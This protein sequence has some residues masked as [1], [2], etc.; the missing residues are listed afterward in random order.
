MMAISMQNVC[1]ILQFITIL[2]SLF[3]Y[4]TNKSHRTE[5]CTYYNSNDA[6]IYPSHMITNSM[7]LDVSSID[8][9]FDIKL[10]DNCSLLCNIFYF[11]DE[12]FNESISLS[13][14]SNDLQISFD[15][16]TEQKVDNNY[17]SLSVDNNYHHIRFS[18]TN[19][20]NSTNVIIVD[21]IYWYYEPSQYQLTTNKRYALYMCSPFDACVNAS[22]KN[23][24][25]KSSPTQTNIYDVSCGDTISNVLHYDHIH[26][27][28]FTIN[29]SLLVN[30][31]SCTSPS[32]IK[33]TIQD[34]NGSD[35]SSQYCPHGDFCGRCNNNWNFLQNFTMEMNK[36]RY[37]LRIADAWFAHRY[38][39]AVICK[40]SLQTKLIANTVSNSY[41]YVLPVESISNVNDWF[42]AQL[43]C[44]ET[45]GTSLATVVTEQDILW[46]IDMVKNNKMNGVWIGLYRDPFVDLNW[47]WVEGTPYNSN[48]SNLIWNNTDYVYLM[49]E[50]IGSYLYYWNYTEP[51]QNIIWPL[52]NAPH[53]NRSWNPAT[54]D[55]EIYRSVDLWHNIQIMEDF[56]CPKNAFITYWDSQLFVIELNQIHYTN[57]T[58]STTSYN[59]EHVFYDNNTKSKNNS[60]QQY[61]QYQSSLYLYVSNIHS[62]E[63]SDILFDINLNSLEVQ[64][65]DVPSPYH[66]PHYHHLISC[67]VATESEVFIIGHSSTLNYN[68]SSTAWKYS[69]WS[70]QNGFKF[71][72]PR[73]CAMT[74]DHMYIY[75]FGQQQSVIKYYT[76]LGTFEY[77]DTISF[78]R[79]SISTAITAPNGKI[80]IHGCHVSAWETLVFDPNEEEFEQQRISMG[81]ITWNG[82]GQ[83]HLAIF[84]DNILLLLQNSQVHHSL[85]MYFSVTEIFAVHF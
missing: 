29:S 26:Y 32:D 21:Q 74:E 39:F 27:Y 10:N 81:N 59:W 18:H 34:S 17:F 42:T 82:Y 23:I 7:V 56:Y 60:V 15:G 64:H 48:Y 67:M 9:E 57:I 28:Y 46:I 68:V 40:L 78:C 43:I 58:L 55:E 6:A 54:Y 83:V 22:V 33:I 16:L 63:S 85:S 24:C 12:N 50:E 2:I 77:L 11:T 13:L 45:F 5:D 72:D 75:L 30:V 84:D 62:H 41:H 70:L 14:N 53:W 36:G 80:Y 8:I 38:E 66:I 19:L 35:I 47:M 31:D 4:S 69:I 76:V 20:P 61:V 52:C 73:T 3:Y 51:V 44:E 65:H 37:V 25:V 71:T 79:S 49:T 1:K